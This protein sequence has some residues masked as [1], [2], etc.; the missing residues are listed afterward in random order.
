MGM[1]TD[2]SGQSN[3]SSAGASSTY[4]SATVSSGGAED[5]TALI[6]A[7][8]ATVTTS[9]PYV[10]AYVTGETITY[11]ITITNDGTV[12]LVDVVVTDE[13]TGDTWTIN[14]LAVGASETFTA[15]YT[16]TEADTYAGSVVNVVTATA[17]D[18]AGREATVTPGIDSEPAAR[19][20]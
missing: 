8:I 6:H 10:E 1:T 15:T 16:V 2:T 3:G 13:L 19:I 14:S 5:S 17:T 9:T 7:T 18:E 4:C 20:K 12:T 11:E